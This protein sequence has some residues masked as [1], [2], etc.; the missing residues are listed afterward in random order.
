MSVPA[1]SGTVFVVLGLIPPVAEVDA[2]RKTGDQQ[3]HERQ[4]QH[5]R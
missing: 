5:G 1:A 4:Q 2:H 3:Y